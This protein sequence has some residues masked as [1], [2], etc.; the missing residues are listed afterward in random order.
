MKYYPKGVAS[1]SPHVMQAFD[2]QVNIQPSD[3]YIHAELK[4]Q[5]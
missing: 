4:T 5:I 3:L 1:I 2:P